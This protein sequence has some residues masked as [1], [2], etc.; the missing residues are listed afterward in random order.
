MRGLNEGLLGQ[1][2]ASGPVGKESEAV[3][4]RRKETTLFLAAALL[5]KAAFQLT[6][7]LLKVKTKC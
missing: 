3:Q 1:F 5:P 4:K 6:W 2:L 7:S